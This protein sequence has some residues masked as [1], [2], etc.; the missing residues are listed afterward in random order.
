MR[1]PETL[2]TV[3]AS[4]GG[5]AR[6]SGEAPVTG[7]ERRGRLF[8]IGQNPPSRG[9]LDVQPGER[10]ADRPPPGHA[11]L[12]GSPG[13]GRRA[14]A[15]LHDARHTAATALLLLGVPERAAMDCMS[16]SNSAMAKRYQHV[17]AVLRVDIAQRLGAFLWDE[18]AWSNA[19]SA[20]VSLSARA[21]GPRIAGGQ[22]RDRTIDPLFRSA[23]VRSGGIG[24][25]VATG[26]PRLPTA[27]VLRCT[28]VN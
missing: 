25:P 23:V 24:R 5:P 12:E 9:R 18:R 20:A 17:T 10:Q 6:R 22:G 15:R 11:G 7:V 13:R 26:E 8:R 16:W 2:S 28:R 4:A 3:A 1:I 19:V 14:R 27:R 21:G